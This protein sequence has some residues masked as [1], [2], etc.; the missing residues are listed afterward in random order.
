[1]ASTLIFPAYYET[2]LKDKYSRNPEAQDLIDLIHDSI[3]A[4]F[5]LGWCDSVG[6]MGNSTLQIFAKNI[7]RES[8]TSVLEKNMKVYEKGLEML[9]EN[10]DKY[11]EN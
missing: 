6:Y 9:L 3:I 7:Q 2:T 1:M 11:M 4:D 10:F 8:I 5:C